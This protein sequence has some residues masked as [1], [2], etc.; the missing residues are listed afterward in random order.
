MSPPS[1]ASS[2]SLALVLALACGDAGGGSTDAGSEPATS[3]GSTAAD[4]PTGAGTTA[5]A[6]TTA[7]DGTT[8]A[9]DTGVDGTGTTATDSTGADP[10]ATSVLE[11]DNF[12][13]PFMLDWCTGCHHSA[14]PTAD[15][16]GA[17]CSVNF[18]THAGA[19][20]LAS[21]IRAR[22]LDVA[23]DGDPMPPA[24]LVPAEDLEL[25][26]AWLDCGAPGPQTGEI[27]PSCPD[28]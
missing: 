9:A 5:A 10:C 17:P 3:A 25:L 16:A 7:A 12:G 19:S 22:A 18:D 28:P 24:A 20:Q 23:P 8:D 4:D 26:R 13:R 21:R 1:R 11:W 14:L 2:P 27:G 6:D 15:R